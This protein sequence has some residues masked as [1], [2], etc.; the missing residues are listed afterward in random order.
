LKRNC[1]SFSTRED[2]EAAHHCPQ[3]LQT[4]FNMLSQ[5]PC[6]PHAADSSPKVVAESLGTYFIEIC[7]EIHN[8][9]FD[10]FAHRV[11]KHEKELSKIRGLIKQNQMQFLP[12]QHSTMMHFLQHVDMI[13]KAITMAQ[14]TKQLSNIGIDIL[15]SIYLFW[16]KHNLL[17]K[18]SLPNTPTFLDYVDVW[19]AG[20]AWSDT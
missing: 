10:I 18:D 14:D 20:S 19:L 5:V 15:L 16:T 2:G 13:I 17:L 7:R 12:E 8:Y 4:I 6:E 11:T 9:S 1:T 3:H